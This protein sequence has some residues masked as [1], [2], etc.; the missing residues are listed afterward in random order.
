MSNPLMEILVIFYKFV[1]GKPQLVYRV[2][3]KQHRTAYLQ[4]YNPNTPV[5]NFRVPR[6]ELL[7]KMDIVAL[8][9]HWF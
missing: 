9:N 4:S 1:N 2:F 8:C 6:K 3:D 5:K 7:P